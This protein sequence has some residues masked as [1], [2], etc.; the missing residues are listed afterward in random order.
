MGG[1]AGIREV[2]AVSLRFWG[3]FRDPLRTREFQITLGFGHFGTRFLLLLRGWLKI[4][5]WNEAAQDSG[6]LPAICTA[7]VACYDCFAIQK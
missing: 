1:A 2:V 4:L 6:L 3:A 5:Y 7:H